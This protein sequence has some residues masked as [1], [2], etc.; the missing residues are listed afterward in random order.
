MS[1]SCVRCGCGGAM[2]AADG[3]GEFA[4]RDANACIAALGATVAM[5]GGT[6]E[7]LQRNMERLRPVAERED[8]QRAARELTSGV[9]ARR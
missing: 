4:H 2:L 8:A 5:L 7:R 6:V 9:R 3:S 1:G